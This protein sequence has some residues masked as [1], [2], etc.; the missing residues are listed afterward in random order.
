MKPRAPLTALAF[1]ITAPL[2]GQSSTVV[3]PDGATGVQTFRGMDVPPRPSPGIEGGFYQQIDAGLLNQASTLR[4]FALRRRDGWKSYGARR[5]DLIMRLGTPAHGYRSM[6]SS[7]AANRHPTAAQTTVASGKLSL[8]SRP[9]EPRAQ[10]YGSMKVLLP[11][12]FDTRIPF[13]TPVLYSGKTELLWELD[14]RFDASHTSGQPYMVGQSHVH[15]GGPMGRGCSSKLGEMWAING[16][17]PNLYFEEL[18]NGPASAGA[19]LVYGDLAGHWAG[20]SLPL[21]LAAFGGAGCRLYLNPIH[22]VAMQTDSSGSARVQSQKPIPSNLGGTRFRTQWL[23]SEA[24]RLVSSNG[25]ESSMPY[26]SD[27]LRAGAW[28]QSISFTSLIKGQP[29]PARGTLQTHIGL[30]TE[31]TR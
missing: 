2:V 14:L 3:S 10:L 15:S 24:G 1:L 25:L 9:A 4:G 29:V 20:R 13:R 7:F 26:H 31:W 16:V 28:P 22:T 12:P 18:N 19:W 17:Q 21:D 23:A 6:Q 8:P 30:V 27:P 11:S 5:L